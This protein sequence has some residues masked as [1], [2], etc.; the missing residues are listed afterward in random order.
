MRTA[1]L[2]LA[3]FLA[4]AAR[5]ADPAAEEAAR[6]Y[7]IDTAGTTASLAVG[8]RGTFRLA[9]VPIGKTHVHPQA[10]LRIALGSTS[11]L[12]LA[13]AELRHQDAVDPAAEGPR[14]EVPFTASAAGAQEA[15]AKLDFFICSD[16]WCVKQ[17]RDVTVPV[18][19]K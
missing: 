17:T 10:P 15:R 7:R 6:S 13:K 4:P 8:G 11:G 14:F 5:A 9:I 3:L 12:A 18:V 1:V 2:A 16:Q 19:V